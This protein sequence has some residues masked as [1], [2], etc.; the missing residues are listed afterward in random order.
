[1]VESAKMEKEQ[2]YLQASLD[3]ARAS[4]L[5]R[6]EPEDK[7][8]VFHIYQH[9]YLGTKYGAADL[10]LLQA[11]RITAVM[12]LSA[13]ESRIPC[14][15]Q[16]RPNRDI[17]YL[18]VELT[19]EQFSDL[20][21]AAPAGL[22]AI[23]QWGKE[24][25]RVLVHCRAGLSRSACVVLVWLMVSHGKSLKEATDLLVE[26]RGRRP[27]CNVSFWCYLAALERELQGWPPGTLP[28]FD[29]TPWLVKDLSDIMPCSESQI[30][31]ALQQSADWVHFSLFYTALAGWGFKKLM[32]AHN[33]SQSASPDVEV[34]RKASLQVLETMTVFQSWNACVVY[35]LQILEGLLCN[36]AKVRRCML[37]DGGLHAA[38]QAMRKHPED[39]AIQ[40]NACNVLRYAVAGIEKNLLEVEF[41]GGVDDVVRAMKSHLSNAEFQSTALSVL[42]S[43][44]ATAAKKGTSQQPYQQDAVTHAVLN[45]MQAH[46]DDAKVQEYARKFL[47]MLTSKTNKIQSA[48]YVVNKL[49]PHPAASTSQ[50]I[51]EMSLNNQDQRCNGA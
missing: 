3:A 47:G 38:T 19:D 15:F 4:V 43:M 30:V 21:P 40:R 8:K 28:T 10:E 12:N 49:P 31:N 44:A 26:R 23:N 13:G 24:G 37:Q 17:D 5:K 29:F 11:L 33:I 27:K 36:C 7:E 41:L 25:K 9:V 18:H 48:G 6:E 45:A 16:D 39:L 14:Y 2:E 50:S 22:K 34:A 42:F 46:K 32:V 51:V 1:M 35:C 20:G